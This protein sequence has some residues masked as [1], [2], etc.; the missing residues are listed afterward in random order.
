MAY[1]LIVSKE[2]HED[3]NDIIHYIAVELVSSAYSDT[4]KLFR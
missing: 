1:K 4:I 2:A 3:I